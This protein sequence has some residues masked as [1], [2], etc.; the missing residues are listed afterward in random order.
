MP[1]IQPRSRLLERITHQQN[2]LVPTFVP[3]YNRMSGDLRVWFWHA[4]FQL[5][6]L[7]RLMDSNSKGR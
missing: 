1:P 3:H 2:N 5:Y 4:L 7:L 6:A